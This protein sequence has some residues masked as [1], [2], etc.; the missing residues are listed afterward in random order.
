MLAATSTAAWAA[1]PME[2]YQNGQY[3]AAIKAGLAANSADGFATAARAELA[4]ERMRPAPCMPCLQRAEDYARKAIAADPTTADGH[5][6]LSAALGYEGRI[7]GTMAAKSK[8]YAEEAKKNLDAALASHP[9]DPFALAAMGGW[10]IAVVNGG[11]AMLARMIYGASVDNGIAFYRKAFAADPASIPLRFQYVLS[12]SALDR[13]KYAKEI[14]A[15]LG[16]VAN[17]KPRTAYESFMQGQARE[18]LALFNKGDWASYD[19]RV[20]HIQGYPD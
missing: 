9:N 10:N 3:D 20:R 7:I 19:A 18:L 5:V 13:E 4:E 2:L 12:L 8:G 16:F 1:T 15:A 17:G 11:G 14:G 6:F